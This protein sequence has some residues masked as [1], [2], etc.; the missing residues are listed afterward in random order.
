MG[1]LDEAINSFLSVEH[2][3]ENAW[4]ERMVQV[5]VY[6]ALI[7]YLLGNVDVLNW[8]EKNFPMKLGPEGVRILHAVAFAALVYFGSRFILDPLAH[9]LT[10]GLNKGA[11]A[12]EGFAEGGDGDD[13]GSGETGSGDYNPKIK[14]IKVAPSMAIDVDGDGKDDHRPTFMKL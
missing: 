14:K 2:W 6:A 1:L 4:H 9:K 10:F 8:V 5:S 12:V 7:F 13:E 11:R 3:A